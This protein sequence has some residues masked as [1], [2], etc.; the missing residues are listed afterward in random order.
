MSA[1]L[2]GNPF[3]S[4]PVHPKPRDR[5]PWALGEVPMTRCDA[6]PERSRRVGPVAGMVPRRHHHLRDVAP[7]RP[8]GVA[9]ETP[10]RARRRRLPATARGGNVRFGVRALEAATETPAGRAEPRGPA[11]RVS[12]VG[13]GI[14]REGG[15]GDRGGDGADARARP[16]SL[17]ERATAGG[18]RRGAV[19]GERA[20]RRPRPGPPAPDGHGDE[21]CLARS[22]ARRP[23]TPRP[24]VGEAGQVPAGPRPQA[25]VGGGEKCSTPPGD[26]GGPLWSM[27]RVSEEPYSHPEPEDH[28][29]RAL[30]D[31]RP[32]RAG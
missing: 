13:G 17:P 25:P 10:P 8:A 22:P 19:R 23:R 18:P 31:R 2:R 24:A 1:K 7:R 9:G 5:D 4:S 26:G 21:T 11:G 30:G 32:N 16:V 3:P 20:G 27:W 12:G 15:G 28:D 14:A 6:R 29:P